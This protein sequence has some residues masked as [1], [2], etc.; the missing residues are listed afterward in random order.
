MLSH[1]PY[2]DYRAE[3]LSPEQIAYIAKFVSEHGL[4]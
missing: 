1:V 4:V 2:G 3:Q